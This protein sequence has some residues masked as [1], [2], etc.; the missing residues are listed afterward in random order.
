MIEPAL[1]DLTIQQNATFSRALQLK[2]GDGSA[3]N[4]AGYGVAAQVWTEG[5]RSKLADF[6]VAWVDRATGSFAIS[7]PAAT[8]ASLGVGGVWDLLVTNPDGSRDYW[9]RGSVSVVVGYTE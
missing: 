1:H 2:A 3:L 9:L 8:T 4:M 5:R 7:L 6:D